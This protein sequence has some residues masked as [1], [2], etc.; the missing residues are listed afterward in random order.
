MLT[1]NAFI[2]R[3]VRKRK[4]F[5]I[6]WVLF[7]NKLS[8][9][10]ILEVILKEPISDKTKEEEQEEER[11]KGR[12]GRGES[13]PSCSLCAPDL[14]ATDLSP[15]CSLDSIQWGLVVNTKNPESKA[16]Y[17]PKMATTVRIISWYLFPC[18]ILVL[19]LCFLKARYSWRSWGWGQLL[20][21]GE[22]EG[23]KKKKK[24]AWLQL[25]FVNSRSVCLKN[26]GA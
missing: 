25:S 5:F 26:E 21:M 15:W 18:F 13:A 2:H 20:D 11:G 16:L 3:V 7:S 12:G 10:Y 24:W 22:D 9:F 1:I 6:S 4:G 19:C 17:S 8:L 23:R 14:S